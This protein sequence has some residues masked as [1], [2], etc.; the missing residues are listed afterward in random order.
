VNLSIS[1]TDSDLN[2]FS[3]RSATDL[4][5]YLNLVVVLVLLV[6]L[7]FLVLLNTHSMGLL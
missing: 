1:R 2:A 6:L 7:V 4:A 3:T 5:V